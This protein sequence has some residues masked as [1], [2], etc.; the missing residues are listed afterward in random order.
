M[1]T[2]PSPIET[3]GAGLV[4]SPGAVL[5]IGADTDLWARPE[6][7]TEP[8]TIADYLDAAVA[9]YVSNDLISPEALSN[10]RQIGSLLPGALTDFFGFECPLG[11]RE[12]KADF[13][14]CSR[15]R[16]GGREVLTGQRPGRDLPSFLK[17]YPV[18][19]RIRAFATEWSDPRSPLFE[20]IHNVWLEFDV[21]GSAPRVP[22]PSVFLGSEALQVAEPAADP[23]VMP[24]H[25]AWLAGLALP[26]LL[27]QEVGS[28]PRRQIARCLNLLPSGAR[29]FQVGLMLSR[30]SRIT[31]LCVRGVS[32][33]QIVDYLEALGWEG[34]VREMKTIVDSL[35][36]LVERIDVDLDVTDRVLPKIGLECYPVMSA[37]GIQR[38]LDFFV[39][40]GLATAEK[41]KAL[42]AWRG[43]AHERLTPDVWPR[44][45]LSVSGFLGGRVHST[46]LRWLHHVKVV[47][48]P[49]VPLEAK[50]YLAVSHQWIAPADLKQM[51][52][53]APGIQTA[54]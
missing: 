31:R 35:A 37:P 22:V 25:C 3:I 43:M 8:D 6:S 30:V 1:S 29:I 32:G 2:V 54:A 7:Q 46:F 9:R 45:L 48:Q 47:Y 38:F 49:A 39:S 40:S 13:L 28:G 51:L 20:A 50:A 14:V 12:P 41:A 52:N 42:A 21:D 11:L 18:W 5:Q 27:I 16:Q 17:G 10:V 15:A 4:P 53:S 23:D 33:R 19:R 44:E 36:P 26:L 34:S 24:P